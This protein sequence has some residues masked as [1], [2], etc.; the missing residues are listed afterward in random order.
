[1]KISFGISADSSFSTATLQTLRQCGFSALE[2]D[3]QNLDQADNRLF[4]KESGMTTAVR[5]IVP[6]ELFHH[7]TETANDMLR[8]GLEELFFRRTSAAAGLA[9]AFISIAPDIDQCLSNQ[10]YNE[11]IMRL[12][13][14]LFLPLQR[15]RI[16]LFFHY[17]LDRKSSA[18]P[19]QLAA[20]LRELLLPDTGYLFEAIPDEDGLYPLQL[21]REC[22]QIFPVCRSSWKLSATST[23][24]IPANTADVLSLL[25]TCPDVPESGIIRIFFSLTG[26]SLTAD[27]AADLSRLLKPFIPATA[28]AEN[29]GY[30]HHG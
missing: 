14:V 22:M 27:A 13:R 10:L 24:L 9:P 26:Q 18:A 20:W 11:K 23:A 17:R 12:I 2:T 16:P 5:N 28:P 30:P 4:L 25:N 19:E 15:R 21:F 1:M 6:P 3:G 7:L 8:N 29:R